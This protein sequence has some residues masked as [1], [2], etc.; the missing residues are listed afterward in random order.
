MS[1]SADVTR[2]LSEA[3]AR[4]EAK[5]SDLRAK[6]RSLEKE[7]NEAEEEWARNLQDRLREV[8]KLRRI[9]QEKDGEYAESVRTRKEREAMIESLELK[10]KDKE[11]QINSLRA[12]VAEAE[13]DK[14]EADN[15]EVSG[16]VLYL[17]AGVVLTSRQRVARDEIAGLQVQIS[18][19]Q[20]QLD[21]AKTH[22][23]QLKSNNKVRRF[24][25]DDHH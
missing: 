16:C 10:V 6:I 13:S 14:Q 24:S 3:E 2:L 1:S 5:L 21:E 15:A 8:E 9:V 22:A 19:L 7:R 4:S 20:G 25:D 23:A 17:L 11:K 12:E 18:T